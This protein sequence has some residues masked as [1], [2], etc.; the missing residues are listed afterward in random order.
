MR[1]CPSM[2]KSVVKPETP[3]TSR[4]RPR[5]VGHS[6]CVFLFFSSRLGCLGSLVLS[7]LL[8]LLLLWIFR[9]I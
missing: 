4:V 3:D 9:V 2:W 1:V 7:V 6:T 8:S 5:L